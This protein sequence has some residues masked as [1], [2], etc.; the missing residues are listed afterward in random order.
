M[1]QPTAAN[2]YFLLA[3]VSAGANEQHSFEEVD[4]H[5]TYLVDLRQ[6]AQVS[7]ND[8]R[9]LQL[10]LNFDEKLGHRFALLS[11]GPLLA[12]VG[13]GQCFICK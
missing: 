2:S 12:R 5:S 6:I 1:H 8:L 4:A 10:V 7:S 3:S 9:T 11:L 13:T